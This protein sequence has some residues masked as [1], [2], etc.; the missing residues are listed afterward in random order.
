MDPYDYTLASSSDNAQ[1][2]FPD[3]EH[4]LKELERDLAPRPLDLYGVLNVSRT[5]TEEEIKDSYKRLCRVFHPDKVGPQRKSDIGIPI[6]NWT[7]KSLPR[8]N[9][10]SSTKLT[11]VLIGHLAFDSC[12]SA[13][14]FIPLK[15][16]ELTP[17]HAATFACNTVLTDR[18]KRTIYDMYGEEGLQT[19]WEVGPRLKTPEEVKIGSA[20]FVLMTNGMRAEF[21]QQARLK[22]EQELENLVQSKVLLTSA[23]LLE[24]S[25][26]CMADALVTPALSCFKGEFHVNVDASQVFDPYEVP[27]DVFSSLARTEVQQLYMKHS[28][29]TQFA[30]QTIGTVAGSMLARNGIG[31]GNLVGTVRHTFSPNLWAEVGTCLMA[32]RILHLKAFY[33][34]DGDT[35]VNVTTQST[36]FYAPPPTTLT[37]GRRLASNISG[38]LTYRTGEWGLGWWGRDPRF[39]REKSAVAVGIG[40]Q[41]K[42]STYSLELQTGIIASHISA[43]YDYKLIDST[44]IRVSGSVSTGGLSASLGSEH[45]ITQYSWFGMTMECGVPSGVSLK[46]KCG[47]DDLLEGTDEWFVSGGFNRV[48]RLGQKIVVPIILS[49]DFNP[50]LVFWGAVVPAAIAVVVDQT[51]MRP[52]RKR[53]I[54]DKIKELRDEHAEFIA[55]RRREAEEA[56]RLLQ[57]S[58]RRKEEVEQAKNGLVIIEAVYGNLSESR[59]S[60]LIDPEQSPTV[61]ATVA[62]QAM[63]NDSKLTIPG[64]HS[65]S[66][67]MGFYDPCMGERKKLRIKYRFQNKLHEVTVGDTAPVACP[68]R[69]EAL[70]T[71]QVQVLHHRVAVMIIPSRSLS[72]EYLNDGRV[73]RADERRVG[74]VQGVDKSDES[75]GF[76]AVL[77]GHAR[78]VGED[79]GVEVLGEL[80]VVGGAERLG[81][82]VGESGAG[83]SRV[84]LRDDEM[85][86]PKVEGGGLHGIALGKGRGVVVDDAVGIGVEG[87]EVDLLHLAGHAAVVSAGVEGHDTAAGLE[88]VDEGEERV[89]LDT[90]LVEIVRVAVGGGDDDDAA[91]KERGEEA[92]EDHGVR[93]VGHLEL[94]KAENV[95]VAGKLLSDLRDRV[96]V[97]VGCDLEE[98][99]TR[100]YVQHEGVE[101]NAAL[102]VDGEGVEE[103]VHD[104]GFARA[105]V[106]EDVERFRDGR[107]VNAGL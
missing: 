69:G 96:E 103:E 48:S 45:R 23:C 93:N 26:A 32:P 47:D 61:D 106:A 13:W 20:G 102:A 28:F 11:K 92:A 107:G 33:Q 74:L 7:K 3:D 34:I 27:T 16:I 88:E 24:F 39:R 53:R 75:A 95:G 77:E 82:E 101:V 29:Q 1:D 51:I 35:F 6:R 10:R 43:E 42:R 62:V 50:K 105:D 65:K 91:F 81:A 78:D 64:G 58:A 56:Q 100:V 21:E 60:V 104:H 90:V 8:Q 94:V 85:A 67:I 52:R 46:F 5:A 87:V 98:V 83:D 17:S 12:C 66:N 99:R 71:L 15:H 97:A 76:V 59:E 9:S 4:T 80:E 57:D 55:N 44:R 41:G 89:A 54:A 25:S 19:S 73:G 70:H 72:I 86:T 84:C 37:V 31:G 14:T 38:Y 30:P 68:L 49:H 18:G 40:G 2:D 36:T 22:K 63:V 79:E